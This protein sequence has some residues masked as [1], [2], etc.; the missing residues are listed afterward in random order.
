MP[1]FVYGT[2]NAHFAVIAPVHA[3]AAKSALGAKHSFVTVS[4]ASAVCTEQGIVRTVGAGRSAF[5]AD[6]LA[7][8]TGEAVAAIILCLT[9]TAV[10]AAVRADRAAVTVSAAS[11]VCTKHRIVRAIRTGRAAI[12][13]DNFAACA[14]EAV[15]AKVL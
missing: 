14:T 5:G 1:F 7:A 13:T 8:G 12:G 4:A 6:Y 3:L 11:A 15:A 2:G 10:F 9:F